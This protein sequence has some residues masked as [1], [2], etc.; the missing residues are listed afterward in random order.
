MGKV[1]SA[2]LTPMTRRV[3]ELTA[4]QGMCPTEIAKEVCLDPQSVRHHRAKLGVRYGTSTMTTIVHAAHLRGDLELTHGEERKPAFFTRELETLRMVAEGKTYAQI[5]AVQGV[6]PS[7]VKGN[8]M[9]AYARINV[10]YNYRPRIVH[11][12]WCWGYL[13]GD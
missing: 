12:L 6:A 3:L 10:P 1:T 4:Y 13:P 11:L 2:K 8:L 7:T 5:A 9:R